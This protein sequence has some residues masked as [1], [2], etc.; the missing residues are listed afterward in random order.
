MNISIVAK[1]NEAGEFCAVIH[2]LTFPD[3]ASVYAGN[4]EDFDVHD[5]IVGG[6]AVAV[7]HLG[8][9]PLFGQF[10]NLTNAE[11]EPRSPL[12]TLASDLLACEVLRALPYLEGYGRLDQLKSALDACGELAVSGAVQRANAG[13]R[14]EQSEKG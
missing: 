2:K 3:D 8:G 11:Y 13:E 5:P 14:A 6:N 1:W 12:H 10:A 4:P 7:R 9:R